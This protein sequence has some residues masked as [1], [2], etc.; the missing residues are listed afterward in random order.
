M[1][2]FTFVDRIAFAQARTGCGTAR[3]IRH[4]LQEIAKDMSDFGKRLDTLTHEL[5]TLNDQQG[6]G[7]LKPYGELVERLTGMRGEVGN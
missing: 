3:V 1:K 2:P 5:R 4:E 6:N 7:E